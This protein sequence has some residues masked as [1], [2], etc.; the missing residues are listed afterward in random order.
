M[1]N[2]REGK[3]KRIK[4][5]KSVLLFVTPVVI[6]NCVETFLMETLDTAI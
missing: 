4:M 2:F 3:F 1:F 6:L 5:R